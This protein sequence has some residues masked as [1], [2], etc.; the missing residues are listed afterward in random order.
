MTVLYGS[1]SGLV[2]AGSTSWSQDSPNVPSSSENSDWFGWRLQIAQVGHSASEDL[3]VGAA[4]EDIGSIRIA[5]AVTVLYGR[6][7]GVS[8]GLAQMWHQN[9]PG[10]KGS[11][12]TEE[13]FGRY[14]GR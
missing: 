7:S 10:V 5:G 9:S 14:L 13:W 12:G 2:S 4:G 8:G 3:I 11:A 6:A 1:S